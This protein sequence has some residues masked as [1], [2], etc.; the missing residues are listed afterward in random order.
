MHA[1]DE[2]CLRLVRRHTACVVQ[3]P[4][5]MTQKDLLS[6]LEADLARE[7]S[8]PTMDGVCC[9]YQHVDV[10][11]VDDSAVLAT[12]AC[13]DLCWF[14]EVAA[15]LVAFVDLQQSLQVSGDGLDTSTS[16]PKAPS[17]PPTHCTSGRGETL[18]S[19]SADVGKSS[20]QSKGSGSRESADGTSASSTTSKAS[21][22]SSVALESVIFLCTSQALC[23]NHA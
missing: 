23:S 14:Q 9:F 22:T 13:S 10:H 6:K 19:T 18:P 12:Q 8:S 16:C 20:C 1:V 15:T 7:D 17:T 5:G 21:I 11:A 4:R 2:K 3:A